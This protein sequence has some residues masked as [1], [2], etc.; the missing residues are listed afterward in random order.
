MFLYDFDL[1]QTASSYC[2][3]YHPTLVFAYGLILG[4]FAAVLY[5]Q[6]NCRYIC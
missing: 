4:S 2:N 1:L 6:H 3:L 5:C